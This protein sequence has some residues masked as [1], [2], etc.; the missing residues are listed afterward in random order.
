MRAMAPSIIGF[1]KLL[2]LLQDIQGI[3]VAHPSQD[4]LCL[5]KSSMQPVVVGLAARISYLIPPQS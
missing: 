5:I 4:E 2:D 3:R 1:S